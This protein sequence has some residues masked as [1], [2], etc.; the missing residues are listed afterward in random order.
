MAVT[1]LPLYLQDEVAQAGGQEIRDNM[2]EF[3]PAMMY[4][5]QIMRLF[6]REAAVKFK[7]VPAFEETLMRWKE[8]K[9][10]KQGKN[11]G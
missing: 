11:E 2:D 1:F 9:D 10:A 6:P 3:S 5:E 8:E 4:T 7:I